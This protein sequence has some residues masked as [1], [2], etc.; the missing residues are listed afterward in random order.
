MIELDR[1]ELIKSKGNVQIEHGILKDTNCKKKIKNLIV[2]I[3]L[4][5]II[6]S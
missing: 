4:K 2:S 6:N 1:N 3:L 5:Q